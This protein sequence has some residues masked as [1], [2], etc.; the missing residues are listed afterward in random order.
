MRGRAADR[1]QRRQRKAV[2]PIA[3]GEKVCYGVVHLGWEESRFLLLVVVGA[4]GSLWD[5]H[6]VRH[7]RSLTYAAKEIGGSGKQRVIIVLARDGLSEDGRIH[8]WR[9]PVHMLPRRNE[10]TVRRLDQALSSPYRLG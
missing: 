9:W 2:G 3:S 8:I 7:S 4:E 5:P 1:A 6:D 10:T